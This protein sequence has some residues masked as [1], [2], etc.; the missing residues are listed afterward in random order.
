MPRPRN[1][2][3]G[4]STSGEHPARRRLEFFVAPTADA[5]FNAIRLP[6][7]VVACW[8]LN[9]VLF[10]FESPFVAPETKDEFLL[11]SRT[12]AANPG[13]PMAIFGH[14]DASG[15]DEY[16]KRLSGRR[17]RV[18]HAVLTRD[19]AAWEELFSSA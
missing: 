2:Y 19:V 1:F 5:D 9:H 17:A 15:D 6:L 10:D 16:N 8:R 18:V 7:V 13:S 3:E 14:A 11:L 12:I 4:G